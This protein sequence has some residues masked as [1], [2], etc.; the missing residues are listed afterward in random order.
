MSYSVFPY[1][2]DLLILPDDNT[3]EAIA[4]AIKKN[5][6]ARAPI[7]IDDKFITRLKSRMDVLKKRTKHVKDMNI[8]MLHRD[9][10][11]VTSSD[12]IKRNQNRGVHK[13]SEQL[14]SLTG[15]ITFDS[16][17]AEGVVDVCVQSMSSS[18]AFPYRY[19]LQISTHATESFNNSS[20]K[21]QNRR[22]SSSSSSSISQN[23]VEALQGHAS[24]IQQDLSRMEYK[25]HELLNQ[26]DH[27][28]ERQ[29]AF[30]HK[31]IA[32][33]TAVRY[34]PIFRIVILCIAGYLQVS[35]VLRYMR[36]RHII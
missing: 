30:H 35:H 2:I 7:G 31:S 11:F 18:A 26:A 17:D 10:T 33:N 29:V 5:E 36:S 21:K 1:E 32:L 28:R 24:M 13:V 14:T 19:S 8:M 23:P 15:T 6:I 34:W 12:Q 20:K 25:L 27:E 22:V 9:N 16:R 4:E 3:E